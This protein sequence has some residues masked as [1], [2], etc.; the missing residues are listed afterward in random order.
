MVDLM[1]RPTTNKEANKPHIIVEGTD[2]HQVDRFQMR[3]HNGYKYALVI[4]DLATSACNAEP[5]I[6]K[7]NGQVLNEIKGLYQRTHPH[8]PFKVEC[9][10]G[11]EFKG[12][13]L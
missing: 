3:V 2:M 6:T 5:I 7:S 13:V 1:Q 4:V 12:R 9:V 8:L 10:Q 11:S